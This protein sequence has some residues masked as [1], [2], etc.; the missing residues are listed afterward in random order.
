MRYYS[1]LR[2]IAIGVL[3]HNAMGYVKTVVNFNSRRFIHSINREAWGFIE[4]DEALPENEIAASE[5]TPE[6]AGLTEKQKRI[7]A[8]HILAKNGYSKKEAYHTA[9]E[10][11]IDEIDAIIEP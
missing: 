9:M 4:T 2:P 11:S 1:T 6:T 8:A 5:L 3:R 10:I 7:S